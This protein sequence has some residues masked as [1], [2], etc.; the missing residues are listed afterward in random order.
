[1]LILNFKSFTNTLLPLAK[2]QGRV[3]GLIFNL[4]NGCCFS[5][6]KFLFDYDL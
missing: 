1:M 3:N 4:V 6:T 2:D 5:N